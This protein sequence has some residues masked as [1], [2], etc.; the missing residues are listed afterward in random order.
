MKRDQNSYREVEKAHSC[1][2]YLKRPI[3]IERGKGSRVWDSDGKEYID[4]VSGYGAA[5]IGHCNTEVIENIKR[6]A[7]R[8]IS[9]PQIFYNSMRAQLLHRLAEITQG[10][11]NHAFLCNSG[12]EAVDAALKF[13]RITTKKKEIIASMRGF[14]G[15]T[16]GALSAT[17]DKKMR[18]P[19]LPLVPGFLHVPFNRIEPLL[20]KVSQDTAAIVLE[21]VQGNGGIYVASKEYL[22]EVEKIC[23]KN[24]LLLIVDEIQTGFGRTGKMFA[25]QH[26][27]IHPDMVC[28]SKSMAGGFP[29]GAVLMN[30]EVAMSIPPRSHPITF[31]GNPL[32]CAAGLGTI[33]YIIDNNLAEKAWE[34]GEYFKK[35]L[36]RI[37]S[38]IVREIRGLGLMIGLELDR[39]AL[40]YIQLLYRSGILT[41]GA[42]KRVIRYLP[43][44]TIGKEE[45]RAVVEKT[46][47]TLKSEVQ[48]DEDA[49]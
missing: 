46:S 32:A 7:E 37:D 12:S 36:E 23:R 14:H 39:P 15:W 38:P 44:L 48:K 2:A 40:P 49:E 5:L 43:P 28:V 21:I 35:E 41:L 17:W 30:E 18:E 27:G 16:F 19:F 26:F 33:D 25:F 6:Q 1:S 34:M 42:G 31:G 20:E 3:S 47:E 13:A 11:L 4:C 10:Y 9:C 29:M 8:L 45:V 24:G 22:V